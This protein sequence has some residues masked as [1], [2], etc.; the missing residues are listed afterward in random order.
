MYRPGGLFNQYSNGWDGKWEQ[1]LQNAL[2]PGTSAGG[3]GGFGG[4]PGGWAPPPGPETNQLPGIQP[5][6]GPA[7]MPRGGDQNILPSMQQPPGGYG[8]I[9]GWSG[10]P[11]PGLNMG[12]ERRF[13]DI[14]KQIQGLGMGDV[15]G[16]GQLDPKKVWGIKGF[17]NMLQ[18]MQ[19][20]PQGGP[21]PSAA[22][23]SN[24]LQYLTGPGVQQDTYGYPMGN[25]LNGGMY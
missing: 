22:A 16:S 6:G 18:T 5:P 7:P 17:G 4:G 9:G 25:Y 12:Q 23:P 15:D 19:G 1:K 10:G 8:Q 2:Q 14:L 24:M 3:P 21:G 20:G 13:M 11:A